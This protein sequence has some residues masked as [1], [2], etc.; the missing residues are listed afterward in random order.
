MG[1]KVG[2]IIHSYPAVGRNASGMV[3]VSRPEVCGRSRPQLPDLHCFCVASSRY[4]RT[5]FGGFALSYS[6]V[7]YSRTAAFSTYWFCQ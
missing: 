7:D 2:A 1:G 6:G 3:V 4:P 5:L